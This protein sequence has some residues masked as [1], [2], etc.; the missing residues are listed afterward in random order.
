MALITIIMFVLANIKMISEYMKSK[1]EKM[2]DSEKTWV[3]YESADVNGKAP[4]CRRHI[5]FN[6]E[7]ENKKCATKENQP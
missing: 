3:I 4:V 6:C 5:L 7:M 1:P 2:R